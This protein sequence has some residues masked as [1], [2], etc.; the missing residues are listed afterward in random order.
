[1]QL[2]GLIWSVQHDIDV[3]IDASKYTSNFVAL[4]EQIS[5]LDIHFA[6]AGFKL[7]FVKVCPE[8]QPS[9]MWWNTVTNSPSGTYSGFERR[10]ARA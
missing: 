6:R 2:D 1:L 8:L 4:R 7:Y 3:L 9:P 5:K 10:R